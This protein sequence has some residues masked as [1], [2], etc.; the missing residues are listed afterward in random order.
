MIDA[1]SEEAVAELLCGY[2]KLRDRG[3]GEQWCGERRWEVGGYYGARGYL[4]EDAIPWRRCQRGF[5]KARLSLE[6]LSHGGSEYRIL[7]LS[8]A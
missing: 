5:L 2:E 6:Y 1:E 4:M 8:R 3:K 7:L